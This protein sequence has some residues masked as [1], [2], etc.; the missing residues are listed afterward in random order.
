MTDVFAIF[1]NLIKTEYWLVER[2]TKYMLVIYPLI[3]TCL[4]EI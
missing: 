4:L 3:T 2:T 1:T